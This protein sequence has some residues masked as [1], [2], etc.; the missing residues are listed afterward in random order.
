MLVLG[1]A[2]MATLS[3]FT[4]YQGLMKVRAVKA[5]SGL[6]K[7]A[8][9]DTPTGILKDSATDAPVGLTQIEGQP[10]PPGLTQIEG[11]PTDPGLAQIRGKDP[12]T[13]PDDIHKYLEFL[14]EIERQRVSLAKEQITHAM[15]VM[16]QLQGL[17]GMK[18]LLK[19][20][21]DPD[22]PVTP[23]T[24]PRDDATQDAT[25]MRKK[26]RELSDKFESYPPPGECLPISRSYDD[27]LTGTGRMVSEILDSLNKASEDPEKA[28]NA[29]QGLQGT[30]AG[31]IDKFGKATDDGVQKI[32]DKYDTRKWFSITGDVGGGGLLGGGLGGLGGGH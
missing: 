28:I 10:A 20:L 12:V 26:W 6:T 21:A 8:G 19:G 24:G 17:G 27:C 9:Q 22:A 15:V 30:S 14:E 1:L 31:R 3:A 29:L 11:K 32:C 25:A 18:D 13:M 16:T 23:N 7:I 2:I 4:T 5:P